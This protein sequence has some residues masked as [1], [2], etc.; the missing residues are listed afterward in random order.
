M[1]TQ[2]NRVVR[3]ACPDDGVRLATL[4]AALGYPQGGRNMSAALTAHSP[5]RVVLV[6]DRGEGI[7]GVLVL[8]LFT[9]LHVATSWG[10]ISA[11]VVDESVR[12]AG[13]GAALL[14]VAEAIC[15]ARGVT[16]VELSSSMHRLDAHR[17]Y[18]RAGYEERRKRLVK[19][20]GDT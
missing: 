13:I 15:Q 16:Q 14:A 12:G 9:P 1:T 8:H 18:E 20:L 2:Y 17:F 11:L 5:E 6:H 3:E 19:R 7:D 10:L 4:F